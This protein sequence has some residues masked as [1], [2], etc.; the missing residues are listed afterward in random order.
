VVPISGASGTAA[1]LGREREQAELS[2]ALSLAL[3]GTPQTVLVGGDAGI[4]KTTLVSDLARRAEGLGVNV[5]LGHCLDI[6]AGIAFGAVIEAVSGLVAR[7][8]DLDSRPS[9]RRMRAL[10]DAETPRSPE[11]FRVLEDLRQTVLEAADAGPLMLVLEDMHWAGRSTQDFAVALSRR[12][13]GRLLFVLTVR[14]DDLHRRHPARRTLAEIST[15]PGARRIDLEP[16]DRVGIAGIVAASSGGAA[17]AAVVRS[18]LARSEGNPL[19]AEELVTAD[20]QA[21][22][23]HLSDL[24]LARVDALDDG[25]RELLRVA[26]VDGTRVDID[27]IAE[28]ARLD[29]AQLDTFL[30]ELRDANFLRG[31]GGSL[32]FRHGLLREAVYDDLLPDERTRLHAE[33]AAILQ[34]R[35]DADPD[36]GL[37]M[38][39][40]LAFHWS[41]AHDMPRALVASE[42]AGMVAWKLGAAESVTHLERALALWDG[43]LD[44]EALVGRTKVELVISLARAACDQGDGER[45][46]ALNRRAVEMLEPDADPLVASRANSAFGFSGINTE[47]M[48]GVEDA[49]RLALKYAGDE[50]SEEGAYAL[51]AQA[52]LHLCNDRFSACLEATDRAIQTARSAAVI[53]S[54]LLAMSFRSDALFHLGRVN[55]A[56]AVWPEAIELERNAGMAGGALSSREDLAMILLYEGKVADGMTVA[57]AGFDEGLAAGL[58]V[59]AA[60]CGDPMV[61]AL[62]WE[63]RFDEAGRLLEELR[64]LGLPDDHYLRRYADVS[65]ARGDIDAAPQTRNDNEGSGLHPDDT[66]VLREVQTAVL[67][68]DTARCLEVAAAY[69]ALLDDCDSPLIAASAARI[70]L[71]TLA[72]ADPAADAQAALLRN[73][74]ARQLERARGGVTGEWRLSYYGVQL[75]LA[76]A[77]AGRVAGEPAVTKFREAVSLAEPFGAFFAL[78]PRLDLAQELLAHDGRDE[79]R[80]LLVDCWTAAHDMGARGLEQRAS[81]LAIR[82]RVQ[83][84]ESA[85]SEGPL[86]RLTPRERE[87]LDQLATGA[88]NKAIAGVLFISEKTVSVHVSNLLAKLGVENRGA[89]AALARHQLG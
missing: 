67:C 24:F 62:I 27:T 18:V 12:G 37:S 23:E 45:W 31:V 56:R 41:A 32:A 75:A 51:A 1:L 5:V 38:L 59:Q 48:S 20:P 78:E 71:H 80:E 84:P 83:L 72:S 49:I 11:P 4:G 89:A 53:D 74:C 2:D 61:A 86:S 29:H 9:A 28:L 14:N 35:V 33:L 16:L 39:S 17:D 44:A 81:R 68:D 6:D 47:Q 76:E 77:Y 13:R 69:L 22:P 64:D 15:V 50:P 46:H 66:D 88:S 82:T 60:Y 63:G 43:V 52:L 79:G 10:L 73:R 3:K 21:L 54:L 30:R 55:E 70:G 87:V 65:L 19:Y 7:L 58:S 42:R 25:P 57:R 34:A 8:E 40:R 36:P 26:S 85:I